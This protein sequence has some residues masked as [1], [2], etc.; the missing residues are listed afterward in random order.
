[1]CVCVCVCVYIYIYI[2]V[3]I[4]TQ[5]HVCKCACVYVGMC[6][7]LSVYYMDIYDENTLTH[8][9][10]HYYS[11]TPTQTWVVL[12]SYEQLCVQTYPDISSS[13][14]VI[15]IYSSTPTQTYSYSNNQELATFLPPTCSLAVDQCGNQRPGPRALAAAGR[16]ARSY[17]DHPCSSPHWRRAS[18]RRADRYTSQRWVCV[19]YVTTQRHHTTEQ[20][21]SARCVCVLYGVTVLYC[22]MV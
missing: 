12:C 1:M 3:Y 20:H 9:H 10:T 22:V 17:N 4:C 14:L 18:R 8:T 16:R 13:T 11:S 5:R 2:Y 21:T 15:I 7:C 6:A 19:M